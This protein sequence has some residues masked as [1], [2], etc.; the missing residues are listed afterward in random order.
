M[1]ETARHTHADSVMRSM[2]P[3]VYAKVSIPDDLGG[4]QGDRVGYR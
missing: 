4:G 2:L 1:P 3:E